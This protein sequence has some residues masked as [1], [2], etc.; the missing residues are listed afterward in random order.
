M[1]G[2]A[3]SVVNGQRKN[4][5]IIFNTYKNQAG[6]DISQWLLLVELLILSSAVIE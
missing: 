1:D 6:A 4:A 2:V 5:C 3:K